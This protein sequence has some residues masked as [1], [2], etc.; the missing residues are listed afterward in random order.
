MQL[1]FTLDA[2][3]GEV[4]RLLLAGEP[5]EV[6][7]YQEEQVESEPELVI[8]ALNRH[9]QS[10]NPD[11]AVT[12][13]ERARFKRAPMSATFC[14]LTNRASGTSQL[15]SLA[16]SLDGVQFHDEAPAHEVERYRQAAE[17]S[18]RQAGYRD[19]AA[20]DVSTLCETIIDRL[21]ARLMSA[22]LHVNA[23]ADGDELLSRVRPNISGKYTQ[24]ALYYLSMACRAT[25]IS[26]VELLAQVP[27][28]KP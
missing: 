20:C 8:A 24:D 25:G 27:D 7:L 22:C 15:F 18:R 19:Q 13:A 9:V 1:S 26:M 4:A 21:N 10:I 11:F 5:F 6:N 2:L 3:L 28:G 16:V 12:A 17:Q 14:A 23:R